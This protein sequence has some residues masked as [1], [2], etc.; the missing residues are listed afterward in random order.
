MKMALIRPRKLEKGDTI[1]VVSPS[2]MS[3]GLCPDRFERGLN[4]LTKMGYKVKVGR[5]TKAIHGHKAGT[6]E[7]RV[8]DIHQMLEDDE[9]KAILSSIGG[10]NANDLIDLLD[11]NLFKNKPKIFCGYSDIT[12][13]LCAINAKSDLATFYGPAVM[14]QFADY[15]GLLPYTKEWFFKLVTS[16]QPVGK[17]EPSKEWTHEMLWWGKDDTRPKKLIPAPGWKALKGGNAEG[18]LVG[19]H[20]W[21]ILQLAGTKYFPDFK[22][23][24]FFWEETESNTALTDRYLSQ[25]RTLGIFDEIKGMI[26]GRI[27]P[28]EYQIVSKDADFYSVVK[29]SAADYDFPIIA[30]M[31]FGHTDPMFTVPYGVKAKINA[32]T[33]DFSLL[34][35]AVS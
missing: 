3:A 9:V 33:L 15:A 28:D 5:N 11:F 35:G 30:D 25:Y 10:Y 17:I 6:A 31:D 8:E 29:E 23:K 34:E 13:L 19:G 27:N 26:I 12:V 16:S 32:D 24:I 7:Q 22:N 1:G 2:G 21:S 18:A 14:P 20:L 4:E